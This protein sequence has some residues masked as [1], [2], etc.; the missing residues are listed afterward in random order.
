MTVHRR[1][2][3]VYSLGQPAQSDQ[4]TTRLKHAQ[5]PEIHRV[6]KDKER[7]PPTRDMHPPMACYEPGNG[8]MSRL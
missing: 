6:T 5:L 2:E 4:T 3:G 7:L 1:M 8:R